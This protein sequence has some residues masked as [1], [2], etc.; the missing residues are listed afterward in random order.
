MRDRHGAELDALDTAYLDFFAK[1][2]VLPKDIVLIPV[3]NNPENA[4][5]LIS[6]Q[7]PDLIILTGGNNIDP[8]SFGLNIEVDDL[9]KN[10]DATEKVLFDCAVSSAVPILGICRGFQFINVMLKGKLTLNLRDHPAAVRHSCLYDG[11]KYMVNSFHNHAISNKDISAELRPLVTTDKAGIVEAYAGKIKSD[12]GI[13][14]ILGVQW[15]P[16]R[17]G[18]DT[19]L[20]KKLFNQYIIQGDK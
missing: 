15:H 9:A 6:S 20:F 16:E 13:C 14:K 8:Q 19:V 4:A 2:D 5:K 1:G 17:P 10:R 11:N 18:A 7:K 12:A 3:P